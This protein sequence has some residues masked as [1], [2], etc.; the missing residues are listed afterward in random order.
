MLNPLLMMGV[1]AIVFSS[2]LRFSIPHYPAYLLGGILVWNFFSQGSVAAMSSLRGSGAALQKTYVPP[3]VFVASAIGGALVNLAF[4]LIPFFGLAML[5]GVTPSPSWAFI[6]VPLAELTLFTFGIALVVSALY[7]FFHDIYEIYTV[8]L[9]AFI[10][11]TPIFYPVEV[12]PKWLQHLEGYNPMFQ[13]LSALRKPILSGAIP[14]AHDLIS[15]AIMAV[16][17]FVVGWLIFTRVE[18]HFANHF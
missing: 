5:I 11:L 9:N 15:G 4:A 17:V 16:A 2:F 7:V 8:F 1:L 18:G 12:L 6:V 14:P 13:F 10:Y 3:S